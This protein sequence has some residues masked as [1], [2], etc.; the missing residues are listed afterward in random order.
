MAK[1]K[2]N[3]KQ[4][5]AEQSPPKRQSDGEEG[6][7]EILSR[8]QGDIRNNLQN[9]LEKQR[10]SGRKLIDI[11]RQD[12][13]RE[14]FSNIWQFLHGPADKGGEEKSQ[15]QV[16]DE[17]L[18]GGWITPGELEEAERTGEVYDPKIGRHLVESGYITEDQ[19]QDALIQQERTGQS[20]WRVLVN[21]GL[22]SPKQIADARKY[23]SQ[24]LV[25]TL[26]EEALKQV[27]LRTG[28]VNEKECERALSE[29]RRTGRNM[30]QVLIDSGVVSKPLLGDALSEELGIPWLDLQDAE[31]DP[32]ALRLLPEHLARENRMIPISE[33]NDTVRV[34]MANPQD[35]ACRESFRMLVNR[36]IEPV[37]AFE[38]DILDSLEEHYRPVSPAEEEPEEEKGGALQRLKRRLSGATP[39]EQ[40]MATLAEDAGVISLVA[41]IMEGAINSRATDIHLEPQSDSLRVRYRIDGL[42]YDIMSLPEHLH[43]EVISR[44]KVLADLDITERR[45]PQDGHF[46]IKAHDREFDIRVA[47]LPTVLGEKM[48]LRLLN[49]ED[50]FRGLRELGLES[51]QL[52]ILEEAI[53]QP[54]GMILATGP[55]GSGK[56]TTLYALLSEVDILTQNVV[57]IEDPVEYQLPGINQVQVDRRIERTF[58]KMLRSV[59]RQDAN[60][61]MVGEIRDAE[62]ANVG[63]GAARTGHL[64]LSTMHTNDAVGAI[65]TL[66]H[67]GVPSFMVA[68][69]VSTVIAQRLVRRVCPECRKEREPD[70]ALLRAVDLTPDEAE[71]ITFYE[72][73]GCDKCFQM[74]YRGRTGIFEVLRI[75]SEL[76]Q[77]ILQDASR[78]EMVGR[79][80]QEGML[81][82]RESGLNKVRQG[83]TTVEEVAR[84]TRAGAESAIVGTSAK[85]EDNA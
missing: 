48:V 12:V 19:L 6:L 43:T 3:N 26:G 49:P 4:K 70:E 38:Q 31:I 25:S 85:E 41:S 16:K 37:L 65:I 7:Q 8:A 69:T 58:A 40:E 30:L 28:V 1:N 63:V 55:I 80:S 23:G 66:E 83:V 34:A 82:L 18:E 73:V 64:L 33:E 14:M 75:T 84:V 13:D 74:G 5:P 54:Y 15:K 79:A 42:L 24:K 2:R 76:R 61:M 57:T 32:E 35:T 27:L 20:F 36:D 46:S 45:H 9:A 39:E 50:L 52:T 56:T 77:M 71:D 59:L 62:T 17:L 29:T 47:T 81:T 21:E 10:K 72:A 53:N 22:V 67:L 11:L 60:V 51:D 44:V 68:N 78:E